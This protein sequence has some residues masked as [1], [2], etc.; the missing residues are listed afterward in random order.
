MTNYEKVEEFYKN[1]FNV[2]EKLENELFRSFCIPKNISKDTIKRKLQYVDCNNSKNSMKSI[3]VWL[4]I[5]IPIITAI[6]FLSLFTKRPKNIKSD[7]LYE[8]WCGVG[9]HFKDY[10][11]LVYKRFSNLDQMIFAT[12]NI[13]KESFKEHISVS[14]RVIKYKFIPSIAY[15]IFISGFCIY[16]KLAYF[17]IVYKFNFMNLYL[18]VLSS[19][20]KYESESSGLQAKF[21]I[22]GNDNGYDAMRYHIYKK[23]GIKNIIGL[24]NGLRLSS[25]PLSNGAY[26]YFDYFFAFGG[27]QV[28]LLYG[29]NARHI[30]NCGK[31]PLYYKI[32]EL[33]NTQK[34]YDVVLLECFADDILDGYSQKS[35]KNL[36][37]N[38]IRFAKEHK[39]LKLAYRVRTKRELGSL[40]Y[41]TPIDNMLKDSDIVFDSDL[42]KDS[43]E[44][45]AKS[46]CV[47]AYYTTMVYESF[48]MDKKTLICNYDRFDFFPVT[49]SA[50]VTLN[51][52]YE[53][54]KEKLLYLINAKYD[55]VK[56]YN[57]KIKFKFM[58]ISSDPVEILADIIRRE[59]A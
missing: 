18:R 43:Y 41:Y 38:Y 32:K 30:I 19:V 25:I 28:N 57:E 20:A 48:G 6:L 49:D 31:F 35:Y 10:Y 9:E 11:H 24:Q 59:C 56:I 13:Y 33:Y 23:N 29:L 36:L 27:G 42:S 51:E 2:F 58:N 22:S 53:E 21:L 37:L 17:S 14:N 55:D 1:Y 44:A 40:D 54:F 7:I 5:Y 34:E 15:K 47:V 39:N 45:I 50:I 26:T 16:F 3:I 8:E 4:F 52:S 12:T 46:S